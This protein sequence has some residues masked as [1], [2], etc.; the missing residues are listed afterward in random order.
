[1]TGAR[2]TVGDVVAQMTT[3][4]I[5]RHT[6]ALFAGA[7]GD[8][9][10]MHVDSDVARANGMPDVFAHGMLGMAYLGRLLTDTFPLAA[11]REFKVRFVAITWVNET[12]KCTATVAA[13]CAG[14]TLR[15]ELRAVD[16][17]G[18]TTLIGSA[19]VAAEAT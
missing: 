15:L 9:N 4:R 17:S 10:P 3:P 5:S 18:N 12:L 7:S 16:S 11:L 6:L 2:Y 13:V 14:G 1:M 19:L 8:H